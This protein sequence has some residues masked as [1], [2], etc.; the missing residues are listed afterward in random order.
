[1]QRVE[2]IADLFRRSEQS[3]RALI[4]YLLQAQLRP[5]YEG[6]EVRMGE[7]LLVKAL[8]LAYATRDATVVGRLRT[9]GDLGLVAESLAPQRPRGRVTL[10][11]A[12]DTLLAMARAGGPGS[13]ERK[14]S[15]LAD[16]LQLMSGIEAKVI[17]RVAQGRLPLGIGDQTIL[18]AAA[19]GA[20]GDR[21]KHTLLEQAYNIRADLGNVV[22]LAFSKGA[23][24]LTAITP[25]IGVPVRPALAQRL[26]SARAIIKRL[27]EV[28]VE[29]KYDGFR[30]QLHRDGLRVW[31]FSRRLEDVT[32]TFPELAAAARRQFTTQRAIIEG[33]AVA[34]APKTSAFLPF[35]MTMTRKRKRQVV[36]MAGRYPLRLF[37]FDVLYAGRT[38]YL[39]KTQRERSRAL[40]R[41]LRVT[42]CDF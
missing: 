25:T 27:G 6:V 32:A 10:S 33:E 24:A 38:N 9:A 28:Q 34:Y 42:R 40:A 26:S 8:A 12:Y 21:K 13:L 22:H 1:M 2:H 23:R 39:A 5:P 7:K 14:V 11:R 3:D 16:L 30:L 31:I 37:A 18:K 17:V 36:E 4:V 15:L 41:M 20:L 35:Q 29:P 19:L